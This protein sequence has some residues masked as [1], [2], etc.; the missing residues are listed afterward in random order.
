MNNDV[1]SV[2]F[3]FRVISKHYTYRKRDNTMILSSYETEHLDTIK[4]PKRK[5]FYD[6]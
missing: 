6:T 3:V 1:M 5:Y 4:I 2:A